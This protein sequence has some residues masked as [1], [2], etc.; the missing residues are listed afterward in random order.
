M[1]WILNFKIRTSI[2]IANTVARRIVPKKTRRRRIM[3]TAMIRCTDR[4]HNHHRVG[5]YLYYVGPVND[6]Y[7]RKRHRAWSPQA[8]DSMMNV[9]WPVH[10]CDAWHRPPIWKPPSPTRGKNW[11]M[12][13]PIGYWDI[14]VCC[15][16]KVARRSTL[17]ATTVVLPR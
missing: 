16:P 3:T 2:L 14:R 13:E 9:I 15:H 17:T 6:R 11:S 10:W 8:S 12:M 1:I 4:P 7:Y 5:Y